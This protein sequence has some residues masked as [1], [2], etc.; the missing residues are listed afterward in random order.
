MN[1]DEAMRIL[2]VSPGADAAAVAAAYRRLARR[3]H[4]DV[5]PAPD[6][7]RRMAQ[8]NRAYELL[9]GG[10]SR[11]PRP[12]LSPDMFWSAGVPLAEG[13]HPVRHP[14]LMRAAGALLALAAALVLVVSQSQK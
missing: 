11:P 9:R 10:A 13:V 5:N 14:A 8:L 2:G 3:L 12:A 7:G 1:E 4:P 6:A